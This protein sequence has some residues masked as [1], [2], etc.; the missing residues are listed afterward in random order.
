MLRSPVDIRQAAE[1][2]RAYLSDPE[3]SMKALAQETGAR[4]FFPT[5]IGELA[6]IYDTIA[7]ELGGQ[8]ALG[9]TP[10]NATRNGAYRRVVVK[11]AQYPNAQ[12][13]TR[14]GYIAPRNTS[15]SQR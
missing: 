2:G 3:Y 14:A 8:Y 15:V 12:A 5:M 9:Y 11:V 1:R 4:A 6:G 10:K 7:E 13:R